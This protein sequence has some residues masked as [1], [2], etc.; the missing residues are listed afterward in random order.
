M[1]ATPICSRG[2][3]IPMKFMVVFWVLITLVSGCSKQGK[4]VFDVA[5]EGDLESLRRMIEVEGVDVNAKDAFGMALIF[6]AVSSDQVECLKYLESRGADM[7]VRSGDGGTLLHIASG[8]GNLDLI[9]YLLSIGCEIDAVD[10]YGESSLMMAV[11]AEHKEVADY[12]I[13]AGADPHLVNSRG[14]SPVQ[15]ANSKNWT[16]VPIPASNQI[17]PFP[18]KE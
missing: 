7:K 17:T 13:Q 6:H 16:L 3:R 11:L 12:L 18:D 9:E 2:L 5:Y 15:V 1:N 10:T 4:S 14:V 8:A